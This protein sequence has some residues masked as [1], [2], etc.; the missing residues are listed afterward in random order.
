MYYI[1]EKRF[2]YK[3]EWRAGFFGSPVAWADTK[4]IPKI[5]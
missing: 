2:K 4:A 1:A 5:K 3:L